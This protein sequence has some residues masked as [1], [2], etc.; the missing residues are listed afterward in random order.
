VLWGALTILVGVSTLASLLQAATD[1]VPAGESVLAVIDARRGEAFVA[2]AGMGPC[3]LTPAALGEVA[4]KQAGNGVVAVG[5]GAVKFR[6]VLEAAGARVP[7]DGSPLH[8]VSAREHCRLA[9]L[10]APAPNGR[11]EPEYLRRPDAEIA[12]R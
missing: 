6:D 5:D 10:Q 4:G 11:I 2:A 9:V 3:V 7:D 12:R 1:V 8:R